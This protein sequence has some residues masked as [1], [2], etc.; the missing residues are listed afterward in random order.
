MKEPLGVP[1]AAAGELYFKTDVSPEQIFHAIGQLRKEARDEIDR[2]IRFLDDTENHMELEPDGSDEP[3]LGWPEAR[4]GAGPGCST[5]DRELDDCDDEDAHDSEPSLG[6]LDHN[7]SQ[8]RWAA[9]ER[10]DLELDDG[11][12]GVA[13]FDGLMEQHGSGGWQNT[14]MG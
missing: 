5:D 6:S 4:S 3:W 9:G 13:D 10:R 12:N 2:L 11:E 1:A 14:V 7:H 8:E